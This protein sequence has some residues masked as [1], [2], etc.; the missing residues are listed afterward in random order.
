MLEGY[1]TL[2]M[3]VF[4]VGKKGLQIDGDTLIL[5]KKIIRVQLKG[6]KGY[7]GRQIFNVKQLL[8]FEQYVNSGCQYVI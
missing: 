6:N 3:K 1:Y 2:N 8:S 4:G 7:L 5:N